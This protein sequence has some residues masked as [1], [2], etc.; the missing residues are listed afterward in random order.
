M[1]GVCQLQTYEGQAGTELE[2]CAR[3]CPHDTHSWQTPPPDL[4]GLIATLVDSFR[5]GVDVPC[6]AAEFHR[7][8][9]ALFATALC[10]TA[11]E[12][13]A[14]LIGVSGGVAQNTL[15]CDHLRTGLGADHPLV[16][17]VVVPANDGGLSLGQALAGYNFSAG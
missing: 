13:D 9:A 3:R 7:G 10:E 6:L 14:E 17:H 8:L 16:E 12:H 11:A 1:L 5:R 15:F 2:A 4:P